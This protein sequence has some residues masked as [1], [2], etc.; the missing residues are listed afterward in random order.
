M[1]K[2][3][4]IVVLA[5]LVMGCDDPAPIG[6]P[7]EINFSSLYNRALI[8]SVTDLQSE[9]IK[10]YG[11][12]TLDGNRATVFNG[13]RVYYDTTLPGWTYDNTQFWI[14]KAYYNFYAVSPNKYA[15]DQYELPCTY[16]PEEESMTITDYRCLSGGDDLLYAVASRDLTTEDDFLAVPLNFRHACAALKF[17][18]IN[19]SNAAVTDVR[20]VRLVGLYNLGDFTFTINGTAAWTLKGN[21]LP[22][23]STDLAGTCTLPNGGLPVNLNYKHPLYDYGSILVLPQ[24]VYKTDVTLHLE[25]T[26]STA[27]NPKDSDYS[28]RNIKLGQ[29]GGNTPTEWKPGQRYEYNLT[30]TANTITT[31]VRVIDWV[32]HYVDL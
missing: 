29:L 20:N 26:Y 10:V 9:G 14:S 1:R 23:N 30:I 32:D 7:R 5:L 19:A 24:N 4:I 12:Y 11:D 17:N 27:G 8:E 25:Y 22:S 6:N 15:A 18:I 28:I 31:E 16:S 2:F 13:E 21:I 3:G